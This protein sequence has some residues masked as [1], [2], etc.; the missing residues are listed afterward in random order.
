MTKPNVKRGDR[1][2]TTYTEGTTKFTVEGAV[3]ENYAYSIGDC[4]GNVLWSRGWVDAETEIVS[5]YTPVQGTPIKARLSE[6]ADVQT[7][8]IDEGE[9]LGYFS[10]P[11][12]GAITVRYPPTRLYEWEVVA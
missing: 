9:F 7:G 4:N 1:I 5:I 3:V 8:I 10:H 12:G 6:G 11:Y 2:R